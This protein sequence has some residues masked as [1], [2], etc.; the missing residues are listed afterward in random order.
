MNC[1][2]KEYT[3]CAPVCTGY[4]RNIQNH[5]ITCEEM[6]VQGCKCPRNQYIDDF[7]DC[8]PIDQCTCYDEHEPDRR[9]KSGDTLI[10]QSKCQ[11]W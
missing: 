10:R 11:T 9:Y 8:V 1:G 7:G 5:D 2:S 4:C 3:D 6:C